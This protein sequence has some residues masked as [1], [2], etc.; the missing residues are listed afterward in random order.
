MKFTKQELLF[1]EL[2]QTCADTRNVLHDKLI[3]KTDKENNK[4]VFAQISYEASLFTTLEK[5]VEKD[6]VVILE[7]NNIFSMIRLTQDNEEIFISKDKIKIGKNSTYDFKKY[8]FDVSILDGFLELKDPVESIQIKELN[9]LNILKPFIG[10]DNFSM[11]KLFNEWA[12]ASNSTDITGAVQTE[13]KEVDFV[14]PRI[15]LRII[16]KIKSDN[17]S[18]EKYSIQDN[19]VY[20]KIKVGSTSIF[21]P[22]VESKL[23]DIFN[24][25]IRELYYHK[26]KAV[27]KKENLLLALRRIFISAIKNTYNRVILNFEKD[28]LKIVSKE[29]DYAEENINAI[30]DE[31]IVGTKISLSASYLMTIIDLVE[32]EDISIL[33]TKDPDIVA[34]TIEGEKK[35]KFFIHNVYEIIEN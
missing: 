4:V 31:E 8:N 27:I 26:N 15:L 17:L 19:E 16:Q 21:L 6:F 33:C 34:I 22:E 28:N 7:T 12:V 20:Y 3:I 25:E 29:F 24:E 35:D 9:K 32:G 18:F 10:I 2:Y 1:L 11:I 30:I 23:Q 13:N 5:E 14:I